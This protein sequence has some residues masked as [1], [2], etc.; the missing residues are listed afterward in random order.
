MR[1]QKRKRRLRHPLPPQVLPH[2]NSYL[3]PVVTCIKGKH[4]HNTGHSLPFAHNHQPQLPVGIQVIL[5]LGD[6]A[7]HLIAGIRTRSRT[8]LPKCRIILKREHHLQIFRL[9][10]AETD[11]SLFHDMFIFPVRLSVNQVPASGG[12]VPAHKTMKLPTACPCTTDW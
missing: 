3:R 6:V 9:G 2:Y 12:H 1:F 5:T 10:C 7:F 11:I 4:I 8:Q